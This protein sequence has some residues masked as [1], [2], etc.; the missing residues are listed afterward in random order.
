MEGGRPIVPAADLPTEPAMPPDVSRGSDRV[1]TNAELV[2]KNAELEA[3]NERLRDRVAELE[4]SGAARGVSRPVPQPA[5]F[6]M[7]EGVRAELQQRGKTTDPFTGKIVEGDGSP[8]NV[9]A[10]RDSQT[11]PGTDIT[12]PAVAKPGTE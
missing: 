5:S 7:C 6:G 3:E 11:K 4:A 12:E 10:S 9:T 8:E 1:A 2:A